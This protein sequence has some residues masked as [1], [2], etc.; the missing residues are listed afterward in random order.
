MPGSRS[1]MYGG[2]RVGSVGSWEMPL[3]L[4]TLGR[5]SELGTKVDRR[6]VSG[7]QD[8]L[9]RFVQRMEHNSAQ[10]PS[11]FCSTDWLGSC[12]WVDPVCSMI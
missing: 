12:L 1:M 6:C 4:G 8:G 2:V 3:T 9:V 11:D 5:P 10:M 7:H